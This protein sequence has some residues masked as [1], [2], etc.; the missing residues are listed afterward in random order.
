MFT[1]TVYDTQDNEH[2]PN[3]YIEVDYT[4]FD[5]EDDAM[6]YAS[7]NGYLDGDYSV[8]IEDPNGNKRYL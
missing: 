5:D 7:D 3:H 6:T 1:L 2:S 8:S 4:C